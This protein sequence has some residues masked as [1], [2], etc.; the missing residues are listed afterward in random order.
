MDIFWL[1][2]LGITSVAGIIILLWLRKFLGHLE[3]YR[4]KSLHQVTEFS[5]VL[6]E[7]PKDSL[8]KTAR[9]YGIQSIETRFSMIKRILIPIFLLFWLFLLLIPFFPSMPTVFVSIL[10]AVITAIVAITAKPIVENAIVGILISFSQPIRIGDTVKIDGYYGTIEEIT[11]TH[12]KLKTWSWERYIIP[13]RMMMEK[14]FLNFSIIDEFVWAYVEFWVSYEVDID[15]VE[16]LAI[17]A[18]KNDYFLDCEQPSFWVMG[19]GQAGICCWIA[20]WANS[21]ADAWELKAT[22]RRELIKSFQREG[23]YT[24]LKNIR[25][26]NIGERHH[27]EIMND[28]TS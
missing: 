8:S 26:Q 21:P 23:I 22:I 11:I 16:T 4:K 25:L 18:A 17:Q 27:S 15:L 1:T 10:V 13:N 24:H 2:Y 19:L 14:E 28:D 6:T 9:K 20:A 7:S 3:F 12:T 5:P